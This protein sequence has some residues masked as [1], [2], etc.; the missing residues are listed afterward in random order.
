[1]SSE[2]SILR[3]DLKTDEDRLAVVRE[4]EKL[5]AARSKLL[6]NLPPNGDI[7]FWTEY[8]LGGI[9]DS[10]VVLRTLESTYRKTKVGA[11]Q[12]VYFDVDVAGTYEQIH[13]L[14]TWIESNEYFTRIVK[15]R[16]KS[17]EELVDGKLTLAV[18][19]AQS[20]SVKKPKTAAS[21]AVQP[22]VK[23]AEGG[24]GKAGT[25]GETTG[26]GAA[27]TAVTKEEPHG[28]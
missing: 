27:A 17:E 15:L 23:P 24:A 18:L 22:A 5:R 16:F 11:L 8:L 4:D 13:A 7:N 28:G 6:E 2:I 1:M 21:V 9:R 19:V 20:S 3:R 14:V 10:G 12:G 25:T 26:A